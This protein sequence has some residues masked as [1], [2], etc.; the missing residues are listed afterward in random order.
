MSKL[1]EFIDWAKS[2]PINQD[3]VK[4]AELM[5]LRPGQI[6]PQS[7]YI[8]NRGLIEWWLANRNAIPFEGEHPDDLVLLKGN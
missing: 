3:P 4:L 5:P 6:I 8:E 7:V 1:Q 2:L